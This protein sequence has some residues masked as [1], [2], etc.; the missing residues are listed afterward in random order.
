ME[1][2]Q[3]GVSLLRA[4]RTHGHLAARLDP[5]GLE[6]EGDPSLEPGPGWA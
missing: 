5:L 3:A 1:A 4:H 6:P 2:V